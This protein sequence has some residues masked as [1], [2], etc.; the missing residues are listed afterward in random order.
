[1]NFGRAVDLSALSQEQRYE[2]AE[3]ISRLLELA[4]PVGVLDAGI[5]AHL[6]GMADAIRADGGKHSNC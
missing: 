2:L 3:A 6:V 1:M 5:E 4:E